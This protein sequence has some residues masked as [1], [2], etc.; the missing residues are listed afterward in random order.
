[1][2]VVVLVLQSDGR[3]CSVCVR[4]VFIGRN[5]VPNC[6]KKITNNVYEKNFGVN[7]IST[8]AT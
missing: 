2:V 8:K 3:Y 7:D 5:V 1:M 4:R 6:E